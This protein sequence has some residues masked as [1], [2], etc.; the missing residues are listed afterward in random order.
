VWQNRHLGYIAILMLAF[1]IFYYMDVIVD[2]AGWA[3]LK[4]SIF[5]T[6][7]DLHR[8]LFLIPVLY[9]AYFFRVKGVIVTVSLLL[10]VFLPR[11]LFVSPYPDPLLRALIFILCL[12]ILGI[13][14][15][16]FLNSLAERKR[17][18]QNLQEAQNEVLHKTRSSLDCLINCASA[19][20]MAWDREQRISMFNQAFERM[21]GY[22]SAEIMGQPLSLLFPENN[23]ENTL[24]SIRRTL[25][26]RH[27]ETEEISILRKDGSNGVVLWNSANI[28]DK[29][30]T[31]LLTTIAQG[32]DITE[33]K[34][35]EVKLNE[36]AVWRKI[37]IDQSRDGIVVLDNE[38][39]VY[40]ANQQFARMLGYSSEELR[41]L[42][43]YDWEY[44]YTPEKILGMIQSVDQKGDH[45][46]TRHRR[47]DGTLYDVEISTNGA[48]IEGQKRIFCVCR[49]I[50]ERKQAEALLR[51][52]EA[53]YQSLV[54]QSNDGI[55]ILQNGILKFA[56]TRVTGMTG[57]AQNEILG[58]LFVDFYPPEGRAEMM[59]LHLKRMAGQKVPS[60]Y[61]AVVI[62][63]DGRH[64]P[65]EINAAITAYQGQPA[66][67]AFLRDI[68]ERK[69]A[70]A[71]TIEVEALKRVDQAKADL[72]ANVSHELRTP[73]ASIKGFIETLIETDVEW[74]KKQQM[75]FLQAANSEADRLTFLIK[76]LLDM[77]RLDSGKLKL[78]IRTYPVAEILDSVCGALAI[79]T[80]KHKFK[81]LKVPDLPPLRADKVRIGQVITNLVENA[82]KFSAE[83]SLIAIEVQSVNDGVIFSVED[84]G[85]GIPPAVATSIFD[86]FYQAKQVVDGKTKGTGLGLSI[87]KGL[88]EAHGGKIWVES[89]PGQG[90]RFCFSIPVNQR[91]QDAGS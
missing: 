51:Q 77:S 81:V 10:L 41:H 46:E 78:D 32:Q 43:V 79:I 13:I 4:W 53:K 14:L 37:L 36:E 76:D 1:T 69:L 16:V 84:R 22:T 7:H 49:D 2:S 82:V 59:E 48:I 12:A 5:Y 75:E 26:D 62:A 47:R 6:V 19:P 56:N 72:L 33:R 88:V 45:F 31:T 30:G 85:I 73:L 9:A 24:A 40:E 20:I 68:T 89:Q 21:T 65:V 61:E 18:E 67:V 42:R 52:S 54:E 74:S 39:Q 3:N 28:Y 38:G 63:K 66:V 64:I 55:I 25:D 44:Q 57:F 29:D 71:K 35:V 80:E 58:H 90:S 15:A 86:R 60:I 34:R 27:W 87:C 11:A 8:S 23:R 91:T 70:E 17:L 50:T 83:G